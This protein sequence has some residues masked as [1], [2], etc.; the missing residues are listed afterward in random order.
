MKSD[1]QQPREDEDPLLRP[2]P[3]KKPG[4]VDLRYSG[5][6]EAIREA[7]RSEDPRLPQ[8]VWKRDVKKADFKAVEQVAQEALIHKGKD[9]QVMAWLIEAWYELY[10]LKGLKSGLTNM[11]GLL[12]GYWST[13]YPVLLKSDSTARL[14]P[15]FWLNEK[16]SLNLNSILMTLKSPGISEGFTFGEWKLLSCVGGAQNETPEKEIRAQALLKEV[17]ATPWS[18]YESLER[19]VSQC[20]DLIHQVEALITER[21]KGISPPLA[22]LRRQLTEVED[23]MEKIGAARGHGTEKNHASTEK[24]QKSVDPGCVSQIMPSLSLPSLENQKDLSPKDEDSFER[25][26]NNEK[27]KDIDISVSGS[28]IRSRTQAYELLKS[29]EIYLAKTEP[30]NPALCLLKRI[31][32]W[33][34]SSLE[35]IIGEVLKEKGDVTSLMTALG[36]NQYRESDS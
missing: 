30:Q 35:S 14:S 9:F 13:G 1:T 7:R 33:K 29:V 5:V 3:G 32:S 6:Y 28:P 31:L 8:G 25:E 19:D 27:N 20:K 36:I 15:F 24:T 34:D 4:G 23:A 21:I 16:F 10:G 18:F 22:R 11:K 12:A 26:K 2:I 17:E